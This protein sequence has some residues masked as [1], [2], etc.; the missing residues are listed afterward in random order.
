MV[1]LRETGGRWS[2]VACCAGAVAAGLL[3]AA[4]AP[5]ERGETTL[6]SRSSGAHGE[7]GNRNSD[8]GMV[9]ADGRHVAFSSVASNLSA[10][11]G[12]AVWDIFVRDLPTGETTLVS[13]ADGFQGAKG[14][15][16]S[17]EPSVSSDG[18]LVAFTSPARNLSD[19]DND[20]SPE[21][22]GWDVF[23]RDAMSGE[24]TLVSRATGADGPGGNGDSWGPSLSADGRFVAFISEAENLSGDDRDG[25]MNVFVRDL[26]SQTT[27]LVSRASGARGAR[28]DADSTRPSISADGRVVA[29][30]S[31]ATNLHRDDRNDWSDVFV[32][33]TVTNR[34]TL[35]SRASG[36]RGAQSNGN[37]SIAISAISADGRFVAFD[38]DADTLTRDDRDDTTDVFVRDLARKTTTLVSRASGARGAKGNYDSSAESI[39]GDG[40]YVALNSMA[41]NLSIDDR[42]RIFDVFVRDLSTKKTTLVSRA[43]GVRGAKGNRASWS[44]SLSADGKVV[45]FDSEASNLSPDDRDRVDDVF[46]R[47]L[48]GAFPR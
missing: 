8:S 10:D 30:E 16:R 22:R 2:V 15:R 42:D 24:T 11:D 17:W 3:G 40:R 9:S 34:T 25:T 31:D 33:D 29:F 47:D 12:D 4:P 23:V 18:R 32:R 26:E 43:S 37:V 20:G 48:G 1:T 27:T 46:V 35:V 6:V 19:D 38:S 21:T 7:G 39:S 14:N 28:G 41:T 5:A 45:A 36:A 13:R 44:A